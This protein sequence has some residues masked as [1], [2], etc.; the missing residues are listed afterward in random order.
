MVVDHDLP[1]APA[2]KRSRQPDDLTGTLVREDEVE[3]LAIV[4]K[5]RAAEW[6][7]KIGEFDEESSA[8]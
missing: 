4:E 8:R 5:S 7:E 1:G 2:A 3:V 6:L